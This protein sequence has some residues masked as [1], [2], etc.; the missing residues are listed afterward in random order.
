MFNNGGVVTLTDVLISSNDAAGPAETDDGAIMG[1]MHK[2]RPIHGVQFHPESIRTD[3][4]TGT[5]KP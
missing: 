4:G 5:S 2:N 3:A 1:L